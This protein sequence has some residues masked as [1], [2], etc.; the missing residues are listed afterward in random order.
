V[1]EI[2]H[3]RLALRTEGFAQLPLLRQCQIPTK[4]GNALSEIDRFVEAAEYLSRAL[5]L[6]SAFGMA[7][8]NRA[9]VFTRYARALYDPRHAV[10][11]LHRA[12]EDLR[13]A[14]GS[15]HLEP[16]AREAFQSRAAWIAEVLE[17]N[18]ATAEVSRSGQA[19]TGTRSPQRKLQRA[20]VKEATISR[21][22]SERLV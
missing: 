18:G 20:I 5:E 9:L 13:A 7:R 14:I 17:L 10:V 1:N 3:L 12:S 16:E 19:S 22:S 2:T 4:V 6:D 8:G 21:V 11:L 15:P